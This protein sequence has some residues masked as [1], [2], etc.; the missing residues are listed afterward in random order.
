MYILSIIYVVIFLLFMLVL[1]FNNLYMHKHLFYLLCL[2]LI[3]ACGSIGYFTLPYYEDDLYRY[4]NEINSMRSMTLR[5]VLTSS[6]W[7]QTTLSTFIFYL[8]SRTGDE[9]LLALITGSGIILCYYLAFKISINNEGRVS[10][11]AALI[12]TVIFFCGVYLYE[13]ISI[14]RYTLAIILAVFIVLLDYFHRVK[15]P[16]K[17]LLYSLM[18]LLH[19]SFLAIIGIRLACM[20]K[21]KKIILIIM[22]LSP[23]LVMQLI[24]I[25]QLSS[26]LTLMNL[27]NKILST[28]SVASLFGSWKRVIIYLI[29]AI[30]LFLID[31]YNNEGMLAK[32]CCLN[33]NQYFCYMQ[34]Y[35]IFVDSVIIFSIMSVFWM[36]LNFHRMMQ[37]VIVFSL[38]S[39]YYFFTNYPRAKTRLFMGILLLSISMFNFLYQY[40]LY[41]RIWRFR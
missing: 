28:S 25:F 31:H 30:L 29:T 18:P 33:T 3:V 34:D 17:I 5:Q 26:V 32:S 23:F 14:A 36:Q 6:R 1:S 10:A 4:Y 20:I 39:V 41:I 8:V 9:N 13:A 19:I 7:S 38:P 22:I 27:S 24:N 12:C 21:N 2:V 37:V 40:A 16:L 35:L 15:W 11:K